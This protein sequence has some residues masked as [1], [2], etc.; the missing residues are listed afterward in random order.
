[1]ATTVA[2]SDDVHRLIINKQIEIFQDKEKKMKISNILEEA[3]KK[4]IDFVGKE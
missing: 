3:V 1:M 4:G 2:I